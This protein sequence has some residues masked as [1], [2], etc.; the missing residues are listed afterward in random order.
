MKIYSF[1]LNILRQLSLIIMATFANKEFGQFLHMGHNPV[2]QHGYFLI[3][4]DQD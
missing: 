2:F 4:N 1:V 3:V